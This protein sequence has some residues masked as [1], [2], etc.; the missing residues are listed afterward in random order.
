M[1]CLNPSQVRDIM[2]T[3][4]WQAV[5]RPLEEYAAMTEDDAPVLIY[6]RKYRID[7]CR[8]GTCTIRLHGQQSINGGRSL[9]VYSVDT[10]K[11]AERLQLLLCFTVHNKHPDLAEKESWMKI[12]DIRTV[13]NTE[14]SI[15]VLT[16]AE[17][18]AFSLKVATVHALLMKEDKANAKDND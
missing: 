1:K 2:K 3:A 15:P 12:N 9:P 6:S 5:N 10:R 4:L 8:D 13:K 11:Q 7:V 16:V 17:H 14:R 18:R